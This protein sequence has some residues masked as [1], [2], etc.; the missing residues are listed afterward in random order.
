MVFTLKKTFKFYIFAII[1]K[2]ETFLY[3]NSIFF[4]N[5]GKLE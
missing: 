3:T 5:Y 1:K 4:I 2:M